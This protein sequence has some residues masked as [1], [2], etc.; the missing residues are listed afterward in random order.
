M[1]FGN[2]FQAIYSTTFATGIDT[3]LSGFHKPI[4]LDTE[5]LGKP[6]TSEE[7]RALFQIDPLKSP[8]P[9]GFS[10]RFYQKY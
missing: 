3:F 1:A 4:P 9:D 7:V 5:M 2:H 10:A 6:Y 8:S